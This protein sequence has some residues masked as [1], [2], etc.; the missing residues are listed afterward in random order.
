MCHFAIDS[1]VC[2]H[3]RK[4]QREPPCIRICLP[5]Q[6]LNLGFELD[7]TYRKCWRVNRAVI[8]HIASMPFH[9]STRAM[10]Q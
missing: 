9:S 8:F 4:K 5:I 3:V 6:Q 10:D 7:P 2:R 1:G